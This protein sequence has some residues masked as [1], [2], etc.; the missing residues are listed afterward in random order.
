MPVENQKKQEITF[1]PY[2]KEC[3]DIL[4]SIKS[5]RHL[6]AL[7]TGC[8]KTMIF[9]HLK[10]KGRTLIL[11]HRDELVRQP[12][13]YYDCS[14]GIEKADEIS[15]GEEVVSASVQSISSDKRLRRFH[16]DDFDTIIVDEAHHAAAPT[17]KKILNYFSDA[18]RVFG[19]TATPKRG[20][21]VRLDDVFDDIVFSRDLRWGIKNGYLCDIRCK[22]V[23]GNYTLNGVKKTAGDFNQ[24]DL[25]NEL[26]SAETI[27]LAAKVYMD[28]CHT[29][30]KHT[31]IYCVNK[32]ISVLLLTA[33]RALVPG[34]EDRIQMITGDTP[35][36]ERRQILDDFLSGKVVSIVNCMV[37]TEGTDLPIC[38]AILNFRPTCNSSLYTQIVGRGTRL[39]EG[40][41]HCLVIDIIPSDGKE[42][43]LCTAPTLF[44]INPLLL[45][46]K[47]LKKINE[48]VDLSELCD[49]IKG[50]ITNISEQ[51][52][53]E[54]ENVNR[55]ILETEDALN[56]SPDISTYIQEHAPWNT[57]KE[58]EELDTQGLLIRENAN[59]DKAYMIY[60]DYSQKIY[61]SKPDLFGKTTVQFDVDGS[62]FPDMDSDRFIGELPWDE[63]IG[64]ARDYCSLLPGNY[65]YGWDK[66]AAKIWQRMPCTERQSGSIRNKLKKYDLDTR[67][68]GKLNKFEASMMLDQV[69]TLDKNKRFIKDYGYKPKTSQRVKDQKKQIYER[70]KEQEQEKNEKGKALF[71]AFQKLVK[72]KAERKRR[73][74][75]SKENA[76]NKLK[77]ATS[78]KLNLTLYGGY[79]CAPSAKQTTFLQSLIEDISRKGYLLPE[80]TDTSKWDK[81]QVS[82]LISI[83]LWIKNNMPSLQETTRI[84]NVDEILC[85][86]EKK[87][88]GLFTTEVKFVRNISRE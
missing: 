1:R 61:L 55:M 74:N 57:Q 30:G 25:G 24:Q 6:V 65:R 12:E 40:K 14:Y 23:N 5:G 18:R 20:D 45:D 36:Q 32:K 62:R 4:D 64:L 52:E 28:N 85:K 50:H 86:A 27:A 37:L 29:K 83:F 46:K 76:Q 33:I 38:D 56:T 80:N 68:A 59:A 70:M 53:Y 58:D 44:G 35:D 82:C 60:P 47:E 75:E 3:L 10:R 43:S 22:L 13:K 49:L 79:A 81:L 19:F 11:S 87:S 39:Y 72:Q 77:N 15:H 26:S 69:S 41:D 16:S 54:I 42:R 84:S 66:D 8:G 73:E 71:P 17:Y 7:P 48:E 51:M 9:T 31:L 2:Q 21:R 67:D 63:A 88:Y 34:E 78:I